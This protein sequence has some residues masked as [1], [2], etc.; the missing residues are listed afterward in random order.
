MGL[1]DELLDPVE[2]VPEEGVSLVVIEP[3]LG[4]DERAGSGLE[5]A[6]RVVAASAAQPPER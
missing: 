3:T 4:G 6:E 5:V 1:G 2:V